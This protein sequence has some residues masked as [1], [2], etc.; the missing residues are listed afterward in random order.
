MAL[1]FGSRV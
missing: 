1:K